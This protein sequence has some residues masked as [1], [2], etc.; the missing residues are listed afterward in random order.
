MYFQPHVATLKAELVA[1]C[2][3]WNAPLPDL[4][5]N[6]RAVDLQGALRRFDAGLGEETVNQRALARSWGAKKIIFGAQHKRGTYQ[7]F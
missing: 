4:P 7:E 5:Q 3:T 1:L 6:T 2:E